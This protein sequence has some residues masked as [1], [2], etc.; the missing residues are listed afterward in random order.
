MSWSTFVVGRLRFVKDVDEETKKK[1]IADFE[2][3]IETTLEYDKEYDEWKFED[4]NWSGHV[5]GEEIDETFEKWKEYLHDFSLSLYNLD[6]ADYSIY[7][8]KPN[9]KIGVDREVL[10][11]EGV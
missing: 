5:R 4:V 6:E 11:K 7:Y 10:E 3:V 9:P 8:T 1:I 2:D